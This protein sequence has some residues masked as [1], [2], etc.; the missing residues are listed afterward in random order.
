MLKIN[1]WVTCDAMLKTEQYW[2]NGKKGGREK[3][4]YTCR[5]HNI[6]CDFF[7]IIFLSFLIIELLGEI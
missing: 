4:N 5:F 3:K 6:S 2:K 7:V 1:I